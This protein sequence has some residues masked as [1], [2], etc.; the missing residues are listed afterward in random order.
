MNS[1]TVLE[2]LGGVDGYFLHFLS[3]A[4]LVVIFS[5]VYVRITPYPE[6]KLIREGKVAPTVSFIGA[7]LGFVVSLASAIAQ[8]VSYLD[9]LVW[10]T[11]ALVV[12]LFVFLVLRFFFPDLSRSIA[13]D[14][15]SSGL[16]LGGL[17][18]AAGILN[19]AC[20]T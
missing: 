19:A 8:S 15:V 10:A 2:S 7:L 20:M 4:I 14:Q 12:Q 6:F 13:A 1:V 17:S 16:L 18:F 3:G 9:M 11:V 5:A